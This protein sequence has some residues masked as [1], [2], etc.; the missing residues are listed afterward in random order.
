M[1]LRVIDVQKA[2]HSFNW[3]TE[4]MTCFSTSYWNALHQTTFA[5]MNMYMQVCSASGSMGFSCMKAAKI[6]N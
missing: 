4:I 1:T 3:F 2:I 6:I 5:Y